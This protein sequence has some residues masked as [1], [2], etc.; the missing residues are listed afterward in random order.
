MG[1]KAWVEH[2]GNDNLGSENVNAKNFDGHKNMLC[3]LNAFW[4]KCDPV[5]DMFLYVTWY[6]FVSCR[7]ESRK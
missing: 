2:Y 5:C 1:K 6:V 7:K 4:I 3:F